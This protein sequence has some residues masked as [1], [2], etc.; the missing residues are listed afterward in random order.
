MLESIR[1]ALDGQLANG[2][3][4]LRMAKTGPVK[5]DGSPVLAEDGL[6]IGYRPAM[7]Y[8]A[9]R[10]TAHADGALWGKNQGDKITVAQWQNRWLKHSDAA[11]IEDYYRQNQVAL[12]PENTAIRSLSILAN[13]VRFLSAI[14]D[15]AMPFI[16]GQLVLATNPEAWAKMTLRHY[17][18]WFDPSVQ[19]KLVSENLA[20]YQQL[21]RMGIPVGDPEFFSAMQAGQ[22]LSPGALLGVLPKGD[23]F[24]R[25]MRYGGKQTFGR[26]QASYN[27]GLGHARMLLYKGARE[28]WPGTHAQLASETLVDYQQRIAKAENELGQYIRNLT[29]GLDSRALG[30]GPGMRQAENLWLAFSPRLLRSTLA[31]IND[32]LL[33]PNTPQ[34]GRAFRTLAFWLEG[35]HGM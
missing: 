31:I 6:P 13:S 23:E 29:G 24:R 17:Q 1:D 3:D 19:A 7:K 9:D 32:G 21:A 33:R 16:Q 18:A 34:G 4:E 26:F 22:G 20:D 12:I 27:A 30:V 2:E 14:G 35:A 28:S 11:M 8:Y 15:F 10:A 5:P 25:L